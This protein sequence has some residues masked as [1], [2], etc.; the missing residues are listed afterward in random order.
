[1]SINSGKWP[2]VSGRVVCGVVR[3]GGAW[4]GK[5]AETLSGCEYGCGWY[6]G[7]VLLCYYTIA[8][9]AVHG[10][11]FSTIFRFKHTLRNESIKI[12]PLQGGRMRVQKGCN[13]AYSHSLSFERCLQ[14]E[15]W[16]GPPRTLGLGFRLGLGLGFG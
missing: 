14:S 13:T 3:G 10:A 5:H 2:C 15:E 12:H 16:P 6:G 11:Q 8:D 9:C 7:V 1:M 4:L